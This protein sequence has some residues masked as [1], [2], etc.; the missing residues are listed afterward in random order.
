[1]K[2]EYW[3]NKIVR[4]KKTTKKLLVKLILYVSKMKLWIE[5]VRN[6]STMNN[7]TT[8]GMQSS[9]RCVSNKE[10]LPKRALQGSRIPNHLIS[11]FNQEN[12]HGEWEKCKEEIMGTKII[13]IPRPARGSSNINKSGTCTWWIRLKRKKKKINSRHSKTMSNYEEVNLVKPQNVI[14]C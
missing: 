1:M 4:G 11:S 8:K 6:L 2:H 12:S 14:V 3:Y 7:E 10:M 9:L 5:T 13:F